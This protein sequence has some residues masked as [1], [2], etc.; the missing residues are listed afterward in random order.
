MLGLR[1][2]VLNASYMP[3][4]LLPLHTVP[5]EDAVGRI[6]NKSCH[7]VFDYDRKILSPNLDMNWPSVIARNTYINVKN[8]LKLR[9][10]SLFYRDHGICVYCEQPI[11][12]RELTYD[13]V[14]PRR[15]GGQ[16]TW[17]NIVSSCTKCNSLKGNKDPVGIWQ[18]KWW[19]FK[20]NYHQLLA[21]RRKFPILIDHKSW[22]QFFGDWESE[23]IIRV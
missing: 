14:I 7:S 13:H 3:I 18:P 21:N 4:S 9:R 10:E 8:E 20:P 2:L 23:V 19:P 6:F 15:E 16:K 5:V 11:T 1:T 17:E 22:E 12:I